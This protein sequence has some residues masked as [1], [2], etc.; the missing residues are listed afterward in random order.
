MPHGNNSI[1]LFGYNYGL[2]VPGKVFNILIDLDISV[3]EERQR[4]EALDEKRCDLTSEI[5]AYQSTGELWDY[6]NDKR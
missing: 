4:V 1:C 3:R 5:N 2:L 6:S